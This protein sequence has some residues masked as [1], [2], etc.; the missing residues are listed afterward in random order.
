MCTSRADSSQTRAEP[1]RVLRA[2]GCLEPEPARVSWQAASWRLEQGSTSGLESL[3]GSSRLGQ[4]STSRLDSRLEPLGAFLADSWRLESRCHL[5]SSPR[6]QG[7]HE[8]AREQHYSFQQHFHDIP[9][10]FSRSPR[11]CR[12]TPHIPGVGIPFLHV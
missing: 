6:A 2:R 4:G 3:G 1:A 10:S 11:E 5:S 8:P 12:I 7:C 9:M